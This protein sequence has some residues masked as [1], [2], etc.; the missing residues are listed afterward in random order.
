MN[1]MGKLASI[2]FLL[3]QISSFNCIAQKNTPC[4]STE[5]FS[6]ADKMPVYP[7]G[8]AEFFQYLIKHIKQPKIN[9]SEEIPPSKVFVNFLI[10]QTGYP[11]FLSANPTGVLDSIQYIIE[12]MPA[13]SPGIQKDK[14]VCVKFVLPVRV[15]YQ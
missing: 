8:D 13:W 15:E 1:S 5:I 2:F 7:G 12:R 4:D 6:V 10:D 9:K 3:L 11:H 14:A